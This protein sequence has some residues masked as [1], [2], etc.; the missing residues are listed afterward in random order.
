[1]FP[2]FSDMGAKVSISPESRKNTLRLRLFEQPQERL[3]HIRENEF[4][5]TK[6]YNTR[7]I[8]INQKNQRLCMD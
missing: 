7:Y 1:M 3:H 4:F 2:V 6:K 5:F 8:Q